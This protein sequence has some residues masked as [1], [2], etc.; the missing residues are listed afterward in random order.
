MSRTKSNQ[1]ADTS[2]KRQKEH[3]MTVRLDT[4][5]FTAFD[6]VCDEKGYSKSFVIRELIKKY[7]SNKQQN[8]F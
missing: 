7:I 5:T 8:L 3:T 2:T 6:K 1:V 4:D